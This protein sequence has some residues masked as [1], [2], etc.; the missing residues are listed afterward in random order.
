MKN[1][2][3]WKFKIFWEFEDIFFPKSQN[4][5][6]SKIFIF[7]KNLKFSKSQKF[8]NF[9][10]SQNFK[11]S[12]IWKNLKISKSQKFCTVFKIFKI[13]K[14]QISGSPKGFSS[15]LY[16][17]VVFFIVCVRNLK[18]VKHQKSEKSQNILKISFVLGNFSKSDFFFL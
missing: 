11:I 10:K 7:F 1:W 16:V 2:K 18:I 4:F 15:I 3:K 17:F 8:E 13:S 12:K 14:F 6:I 9:R 5:K